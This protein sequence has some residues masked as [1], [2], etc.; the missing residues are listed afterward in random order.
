[1]S[2]TQNP[3]LALHYLQQLSPYEWANL[4][5]GLSIGLSTLGAAWGIFL[6]ASSLLGA[7]IRTP[8][9][10]A[11]NLI[12]I[13]FCEA[14]GIYGII[15]SIIFLQKLGLIKTAMPDVSDY[16]G[17]FGLFGGGLSVGFTNLFCGICVGL[18]GS[19]CA[20]ADAAEP[21]MFVKILVIEIFG[22]ALGLF[23]VIVGIVQVTNAVIG[24]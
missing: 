15:M 12:S 22:S 16:F 21:S 3:T 24:K 14:V 2:Q 5:V 1:M 23:G 4:G 6:T 10:R 11:K 20:L 8:R 18:V 17:G 7:S 13:I 9:I 19:G